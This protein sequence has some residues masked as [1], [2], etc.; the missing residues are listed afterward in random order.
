MNATGGYDL[1]AAYAATRMATSGGDV[2]PHRR[3]DGRPPM[4]LLPWTLLHRYFVRPDTPFTL[5][6]HLY[7]REIYDCTARQVRVKKSGQSGLSELLVSL[8]LHA[9]DER[10]LD[11]LY[12]MPTY[13][14]MRDFSQLRFEPAVQASPHLSRLLL[15]AGKIHGRTARQTDNVQIKVIGNNNLVL[16]GASVK[17]GSKPQKGRANRLKSVPADLI[18]LDEYDEMDQQVLPLA[19]MRMGH[20]PVKQEWLVSTPTYPGMG[21]DYEWE[22]TD[23]REWFVP[24]PHCGHR[25]FLTMA[26]IIIEED[27]FERP[28]AWHGQA[29]GRAYAACERCGKELNRLAAGEWVARQPGKEIVGF[30]VTKLFSPHTPLIDIVKR[31]D[32]LEEARRREAYNQD[33]GEAYEPRGGRLSLELLRECIRPYARGPLAADTRTYMGVDVSP[34]GLHVIVRGPDP[35]RP[36]ERRL[37]LAEEVPGFYDVG[38]YM[39]LFNVAACVV[40]AAPETTQAR[41]LQADFLDGQVWLAYFPWTDAGSTNPEPIVWDEKKGIVNMDRTRVFDGM[42]GRF[43]DQ[44]NTLPEDGE[45]IPGYFEQLRAPVRINEKNHKGQ[46]ISRYS[47][48]SNPDH[49]A[50]AEVYCYAASLRNTWWII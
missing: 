39:R 21:I 7:L 41:A 15:P 37:L 27:K 8:A 43:K 23:Q 25:Q 9:C 36:G 34:N 14:D 11:V 10:R 46:T 4:P 31:R 50:L 26:H 19:Q 44:E 24:C 17:D 28:V 45:Q 18:I 20:S 1:H 40:D 29:E 2:V 12:L 48:G 32:T 49:F 33:L 30:H 13:G 22:F 35:D 3:T 42:Y 16:R 6:D 5:G 38:R 47:E